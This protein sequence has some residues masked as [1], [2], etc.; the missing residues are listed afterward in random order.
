MCLICIIHRDIRDF[1]S[2]Q[3]PFIYFH[4][5]YLYDIYKFVYIMD[6]YNVLVISR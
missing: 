3:K 1:A 6:L 2:R 4:Y 5:K